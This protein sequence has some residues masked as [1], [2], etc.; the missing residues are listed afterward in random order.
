MNFIIVQ[1]Q[2]KRVSLSFLAFCLTIAI[3]FYSGEKA[4]GLALPTQT[5]VINNLQ[6]IMPDWKHI[7]FSDLPPIQSDGSITNGSEKRFW[8]KG[9]TPDKFLTLQDISS[10]LFPNLLNL[11]NIIEATDDNSLLSLPLPDFPLVGSQ[12]LG[13]LL[14]LLP[15]LGKM[16]L[17]KVMPI[18]Q[19]LKSVLKEDLTNIQDL[20]IKKLLNQTPALKDLSLNLIDLQ[21]YPLS[22]FK[23]IELVQ[24]GKFKDWEKAYINQIPG[25]K[26]LPLAK[27]PVPLTAHG[28]ETGK[29]KYIWSKQETP[30][31]TI[32]GSY[33]VGFQFPCAGKECSNLELDLNNPTQGNKTNVNWIA[34]QQK[35]EG[36]NGCLS[37]ANGGL[38]STGRHPFG[39]LFKVVVAQLDEVKEV[40]KTALY[41]RFSNW[42]GNS[43]YIVGPIAFQDYA[44]DSNIFLG[45][46]DEDFTNRLSTNSLTKSSQQQDLTNSINPKRIAQT[47][48]SVSKTSYDDISAFL[49]NGQQKGRVLGL[50][51]LSSYEPEVKEAI[52]SS[53]GGSDWLKQI[54]QGKPI[55]VTDLRTYFSPAIQDT[56]FQGLI[57]VRADSTVQEIDPNTG[58]LFAGELLALRI[59]EKICFGQRS[60]ANSHINKELLNNLKENYRKFE[61]N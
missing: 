44:V 55:S 20:P 12:T 39:S 9:Q 61:V 8:T 42:C 6:I 40:A 52:T 15:S 60:K 22:L 10:S 26:K 56:V 16:E 35:V 31:K 3:A 25:L 47:L 37:K 57:K 45:S 23:D 54:E 58:Q 17:K 51:S 24:L 28:K 33:K 38:E 19:L 4:S 2:F 7:A 43:P 18:Y 5:T 14:E 36:G 34:S 32:S 13:N 48:V 46:D 59:M 49:V 30:Q 53:P 27:Y 1:K 21:P 50:Y 29:I 41:F 11:N